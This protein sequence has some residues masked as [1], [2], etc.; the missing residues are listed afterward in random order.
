MS[1]VKSR[2][3]LLREIRG[4]NHC[5]TLMIFSLIHK[6]IQLG[7]KSELNPEERTSDPNIHVHV[8]D[9]Y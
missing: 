3:G 8:C 4:K 7:K 1:I 5:I 6:F 9:I 2:P